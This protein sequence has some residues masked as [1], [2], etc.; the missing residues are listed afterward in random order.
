MTARLTIAQLNI[1]SVRNKLHDINSLL[2]SHDIDILLLT[3]SNLNSS[4]P[5]SLLEV[6]G[7]SS[8]RKDREKRKGGGLL[9]YAKNSLKVSVVEKSL[10]RASESLCIDVKLSRRKRAYILLV[11]RPPNSNKEA[12]ISSFEDTINAF[13]KEDYLFILG[14]MNIDLLSTDHCPFRKRYMDIIHAYDFLQVVSSPTRMGNMKNSLL[15][16]LII[17]KGLSHYTSRVIDVPFS[18]HEAI[19]CAWDTELDI[20]EQLHCT[21]TYRCMNNFDEKAFQHSLRNLHWNDVLQNK[22]LNEQWN[23]FRDK[24]L[25][26]WHDMA[27]LKTVRLRKKTKHKA[28]ITREIIS[29]MR[30][31]DAL[32]KKYKVSYN[33]TDWDTF[34]SARN[35]VNSMVTRSKYYYLSN[36]FCNISDS[37]EAWRSLNPF[38]GRIKG[39]KRIPAADLLATHFATVPM[40]T[41]STIPNVDHTSFIDFLGPPAQNKCSMEFCTLSKVE[42]VLKRLNNSS[43]QGTDGISNMILRK[44]GN[45]IALPLCIIFNNCINLKKVPDQWKVA[46]ITAIHKSGNTCDPQNYR[47]IS[48]LCSVSKLYEKLIST[49]VSDFLESN[50]LLS[51]SQHGFRPFRSTIS[52]LTSLT[53]NILNELNNNKY[54]PLLLLDLSK[55]FDTVDHDILLYKIKHI[56]L[57]ENLQSI[58][59]DYLSNRKFV[60]CSNKH[61]STMQDVTS[62]VPQGSVLGPLLFIIY[63][64]DFVNCLDVALATQYADDTAV[65]TSSSDVLAARCV[66]END[67]KHISDWFN[68]NKLKLNVKKTQFII[69]GTRHLMRNLDKDATLQF[70]GEFVPR[71]NCIN[72]LGLK[73]DQCFTFD[74]HIHGLGTKISRILG[75]LN[76]IKHCLP[77]CLRRNI[78]QS[79]VIPHFI[80]GITIYSRTSNNNLKYLETL[81]NRTCR[82]VLQIQPRDMHRA[83]MYKTLKWMNFEQLITYHTS[84]LSFKIITGPLTSIMPLPPTIENIHSY[85]TR[86]S[87]NFSHVKINNSYG[88][89]RSCYHVCK[90]WNDLSTA[91][92]GPHSLARFKHILKGE[93]LPSD[94]P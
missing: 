55:A 30:K 20:N 15:D 9:I 22:T 62:G 32:Y 29:E 79:L 59:C 63:M 6:T 50:L 66:L 12:F 86:N 60:V 43:A 91:T 54:V 68:V 80:Y 44:A 37:K 25:K 49:A 2:L 65:Y 83:E 23:L 56:G 33:K 52:A 82:K 70:S 16:H 3:E 85:A 1:N 10:M 36:K 41:Q 61:Q 57:D 27:P 71:T 53:D 7:Y 88:R 90:T 5:S 45:A 28:W 47:P 8:W 26:V 34:K 19:L 92:K 76:N 11:Y 14:D 64:N 39:N 38:L 72:Y 13:N 4:F 77:L 73:L 24:F 78:Y 89:K 58:V 31:R 94:N 51:G 17:K 18:D 67:L 81:L 46:K 48:L 35:K 75:T 87:L 21:Y 74:D 42:E 69:F 40:Q 84:I 93:L